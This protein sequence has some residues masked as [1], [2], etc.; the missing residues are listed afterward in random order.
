MH[1]KLSKANLFFDVEGIKYEV[2]GPVMYEKPT[3]L[4]LHGGPA[5]DHSHYKPSF[6]ELSD[7]AQI[8]YLDQRGHGRSDRDVSSNWN[9]EQWADDV[10]QFCDHLGIEKPIV[11]GGSF[12]GFVAM[13]YACKYPE[14]PGKLILASTAPYTNLQRKLAAFERLGGV[15]AR[16]VA[17]EF[18][19]APTEQAVEEYIEICMP[20]YNTQP[21]D[22]D[23][24]RRAIMNPDVF[25]HFVSVSREMHT[26]DLRDRLGDVICPTLITVGRHDP[27]TPL[28]DSQEILDSLPPGIGQLEIFDNSGHGVERDEPE[29]AFAL[30]RRFIS[31]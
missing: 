9:L 17:E 22:P 26:Y 18:W 21:G 25:M 8:V 6:S 13:A 31:E 4:L 30:Y 2:R 12:G 5:F 24:A 14:D 1:I 23:E 27:I 29:K 15:K 10:K 3:L 20:L 19:T 7:S 28:E 11:L 16:Q